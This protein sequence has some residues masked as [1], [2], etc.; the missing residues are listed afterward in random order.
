[1]KEALLAVLRRPRLI[2]EQLVCYAVLGYLAWLW[3]GMPVARWW[4]IAA[5]AISAILWFVALCLAGRRAAVALRRD[6][7]KPPVPQRVA[8]CTALGALGA[9][10]SY[11]LI[12]WVPALEGLTAQAVSFALRFGLAYF[13]LIFCWLLIASLTAGGKPVSTQ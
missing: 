11:T 13:L 7:H 4:N 9:L 1:M 8:L 2:A 12:N 5:L 3:L 6:S 10:A